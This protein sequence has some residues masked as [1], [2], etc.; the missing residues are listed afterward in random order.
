MIE[1]AGKRGVFVATDDEVTEWEQFIRD[2][3]GGYVR[4]F[5][6]Q[7][8]PEGLVLRGHARTYY[9]KQLAQHTVMTL[10]G[11]PITANEIEVW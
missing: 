11:R 7:V 2:R 8:E 3:L 6:I 10:S 1:S 5:R 9:A 4:G